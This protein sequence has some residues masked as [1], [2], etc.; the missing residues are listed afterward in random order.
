MNSGR[1]RYLWLGIVV[2]VI[3]IAFAAW[4]A[5]LH[6]TQPELWLNTSVGDFGIPTNAK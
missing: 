3:L 4:G 5:Y 6:E 2:T 1:R